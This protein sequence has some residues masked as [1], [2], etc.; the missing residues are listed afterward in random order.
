[1]YTKPPS[2]MISSKWGKSS[3][4]S[5]ILN[6]FQ[7]S[8]PSSLWII[9]MVKDPQPNSNYGS[10]LETQFILSN[11]ILPVQTWSDTSVIFFLELQIKY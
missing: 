7:V 4:A 9:E 6:V 10:V 5:I 8:K 3:V 11:N 1:M 2:D